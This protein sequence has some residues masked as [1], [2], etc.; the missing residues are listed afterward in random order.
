MSPVRDPEWQLHI[1]QKEYTIIVLTHLLL[2]FYLSGPVAGSQEALTAGPSLSAPEVKKRRI[3]CHS[4]A[5][6]KPCKSYIV[7]ESEA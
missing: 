4:G 7:T 6:F 2:R 3:R 5:G 1:P